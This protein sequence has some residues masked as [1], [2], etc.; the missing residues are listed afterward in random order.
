MGTLK[1]IERT[2]R[3][4]QETGTLD[5]RFEAWGRRSAGLACLADLDQLIALCRK[6]GVS[7]QKDA[8]LAALCLE[9]KRDKTAGVV[10]SW[11]MLPGLWE[12][13]RELPSD[14]L[15]ADDLEAELVAGLWTTAAEVEENTREVPGRLVNGARW[16][17]QRAIR[18]ALAW[19]SW[20]VA[21]GSVPLDR[22]T[23]GE[24][25]E[26]L[27]ARAVVRGIVSEDE[28]E[29]LL[30]HRSEVVGFAERLGISLAVF[31]GR[32]TRARVRLAR[33]LKNGSRDIHVR[34][35]G[36]NR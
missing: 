36:A 18:K 12:A 14:V 8:T 29:M 33:W 17:A 32:R 9:A 35:A 5:S 4:L 22:P 20:V 7:Q 15:D 11:L 27:L 16:N 23:G 19:N 21:S 30:A 24:P 31:Q 25:E 34:E 3:T 1:S 28:I 26:D 13:V 2:F 10:L 6:S